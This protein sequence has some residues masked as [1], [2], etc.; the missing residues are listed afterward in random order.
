[1]YF[2]KLGLISLCGIMSL[3]AAAPAAL[4]DAAAKRRVIRRPVG[5]GQQDG[6]NGRESQGCST[7]K[8]HQAC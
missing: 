5:A 7:L 1:M 8:G 4:A 6:L 3:A 2:V